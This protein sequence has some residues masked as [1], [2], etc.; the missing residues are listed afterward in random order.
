MTHLMPSVHLAS[1]CYNSN[2]SMN[3]YHK[4]TD[5]LEFSSLLLE[6]LP[7]VFVF[8]EPDVDSVSE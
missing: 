6:L 5:A 4:E 2:R 1:E 3:V 7:I 8:R